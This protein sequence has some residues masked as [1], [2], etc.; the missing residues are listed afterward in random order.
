MSSEDIE[1][2]SSST[3]RDEPMAEAPKAPNEWP[4]ENDDEV[5]SSLLAATSERRSPSQSYRSSNNSSPSSPPYN[6]PIAVDDRTSDDVVADVIAVSFDSSTATTASD[7]SFVQWNNAGHDGGYANIADRKKRKSE[8]NDNND[9]TWVRTKAW[10]MDA[11]DDAK[12][13]APTCWQ[14][15]EAAAPLNQAGAV[16]MHDE[17]CQKQRECRERR[18]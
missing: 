5:Q 1:T 9:G 11:W 16:M 7:T 12:R 4:E 6:D 3:P 8:V 13:V 10:L 14:C 15:W 18:R 2:R 17:L